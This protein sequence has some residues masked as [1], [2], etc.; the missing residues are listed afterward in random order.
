MKRISILLE[1]IVAVRGECSWKI[2]W[3]THTLCW[4]FNHDEKNPRFQF[5]GKSKS[6]EISRFRTRYASISTV[7]VERNAKCKAMCVREIVVTLFK[8]R[9]FDATKKKRW[10][11]F[12]TILDM[13]CTNGIRS[14]RI[15]SVWMGGWKERK[16][17]KN[18]EPEQKSE[19][20]TWRLENGKG[21]AGL[22]SAAAAKN[23]RS[24][25]AAIRFCL[26]AFGGAFFASHFHLS[27]QRSQKEKK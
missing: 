25:F 9:Q 17:E 23:L 12:I 18:G 26:S 13:W 16:N 4:L 20:L 7:S 15:G 2:S 8:N 11:W 6:T 10:V 14:D 1:S 21:G 24:F 19:G 27:F 22:W 3:R 5:E